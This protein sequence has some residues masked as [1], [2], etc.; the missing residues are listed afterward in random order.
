MDSQILPTKCEHNSSRHTHFYIPRRSCT[1][2]RLKLFC[3]LRKA[4]D[5]LVLDGL[6][7]SFIRPPSSPYAILRFGIAIPRIWDTPEVH[8]RLRDMILSWIRSD[9]SYWSAFGL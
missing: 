1:S 7:D 4:P 8:S 6:L 5:S 9:P 3:T 2:F